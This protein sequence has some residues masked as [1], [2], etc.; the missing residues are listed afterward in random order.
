MRKTVFLALLL[1][2]CLLL[3]SCSL[4][5]KDPVVDAATEIVKVNGTAITKAEVN[6]QVN[7][8]LDYLQQYYRQNYGQ[9]IDVTSAEVVSAARTEVVEGLVEREV[10]RQKREELMGDVSAIQLTDEEKAEAAADWQQNYD[11]IKSI[12]HGD[13]ELT[14]DELDAAV[15]ADVKNYLGI[16]EDDIYTTALNDKIDQQFRAI[17]TKDVTVS[18]DEVKAEFDRLAGED[19]TKYEA[20]LSAYGTAVNGDSATVYYRPAGYRMVRQILVKYTEAD[21]KII[22]DLTAKVNAEKSTVT[23]LTSQLTNAGVTDVDALVGQV[24]VTLEDKPV[25]ERPETVSG[26]A[27]TSYATVTDLAVA[28]SKTAFAEGTDE[29]TADTARQLAE[30]K[31]RQAAYEAALTEATGIALANIKETADT[32]VEAARG[33]FDWNELVARYNQDPGMAAGAAHAETGYAVCENMSGFDAAFTAAA[34]A[35]QNVGDV[36]DPAAGAYGYYIIRYESDVAEGPVELTQEIRDS[37]HDSLLSTKQN[38]FYDKAVTQWVSEAKV[39]RF[40]DRL[41]K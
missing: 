4:I 16:T 22:D 20:D 9:S 14:G 39:E 24:T 17:V 11:M 13:S 28:D 26:Y 8:Y 35:L 15:R 40:L 3:S 21:Q 10:V 12:F 19:K 27:A 25:V 37:L 32:V 5:V 30:A 6:E 41:D 33:G 36:S 18:D 38:E 2:A 29:T 34:M 23:T 7:A 1:A 31:A